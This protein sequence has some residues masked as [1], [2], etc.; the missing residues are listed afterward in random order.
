MID[1]IY[2]MVH[3]FICNVNSCIPVPDRMLSSVAILNIVSYV[4]G[5][6]SIS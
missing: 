2:K 3:D 5:Y 6:Y 1:S 4:L